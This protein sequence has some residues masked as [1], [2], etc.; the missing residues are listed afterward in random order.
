[1]E[2]IKIYNKDTNPHSI[3]KEK[4]GDDE[5]VIADL[6]CYKIKDRERFYDRDHP[7]QLHPESI[8]YKDYWLDFEKRCIEGWWVEDADGTWVFMM[9]K[10]FYFINYVTIV[11]ADRTRIKPW[12]RDL[13]WIYATYWL[14]CEGFSGFENDDVYT[15]HYLVKKVIDG[16]IDDV[17]KKKIPP[18]CYN[19][20]GELK[21]Y[22]DPWIFLTRTYLIDDPRGPL[23]RPLYSP[24]K[25]TKREGTGLLD[26]LNRLNALIFGCRGI[27]KTLHVFQGIVMHEFTFGGVKFMEDIDYTSRQLLIGLGCGTKDQLQRSINNMKSFYDNQPGKFRFEEADQ[28]DYMGSFYKNYQGTFRVGSHFQHIIKGGAGGATV[29]QFGSSIQ[30]SVIETGRTTIGAGDRQRLIVLEEAGFLG[31]LLIDTYNATRDSMKISGQKVGHFVVL[32]TAGDILKVREAKKMFEDPNGYEAFG[33]PNYWENTSKK[34]GL[35]I[36]V[37]YQYRDYEDDQ[38]NLKIREALDAFKKD[39]KK[40]A[41]DLDS[42]AFTSQ[43][44]YNPLVPRDMLI[45]NTRSLL[46]KKEAQ[47]H[48][49]DIEVNDLYQKFANAGRLEWDSTQRYG[50]RFDKDMDGT[51]RVISDYS[52]DFDKINKEGRFVM[53]ESP[54]EYIPEFTYFVCFDPTK[55]KDDDGTS[56]NGIVVY[57]HFNSNGGWLNDGIAAVWTGRFNTLDENYQQVVKIAKYFNATIFI[58]TNTGGWVKMFRENGHFDMLQADSYA[59]E[60]ELGKGKWKR[61]YHKIGCEM[62]GRKKEYAIKALRDWLTEVRIRDEVTN[63]PTKRNMDYIFSKRILAEIINHNPGGNYDLL[64]SLYLLM[65]LFD[66]L[67]DLTPKKEVKSVLDGYDVQDTLDRQRHSQQSRLDRRRASFLETM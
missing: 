30:M 7:K 1:M 59:L 24:S 22:V 38:G 64:S 35:F 26:T 53:F 62:T 8:L 52:P 19:K 23:G 56:L 14:C 16:T 34:I 58:E 31:P 49:S 28:P 54:G 20:K 27:S 61:N 5:M 10:L 46:P 2:H 33:I 36:S 6:F 65:I 67:N 40:W 18:S 4:V 44:M 42:V 51:G 39:K 3:L 57:K 60:K 12:L 50:V 29:E 32:G 45:P 47:N 66:Q 15:S 25:Q 41:E 13:E 9:P 55:A 48:L 11:G 63:A 21:E 17:Q 37:L 43:M